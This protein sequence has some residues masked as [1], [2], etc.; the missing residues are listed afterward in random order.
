MPTSVN[1]ARKIQ[2]IINDFLTPEQA[3]EVTRRLDEEV[4]KNTDN[5]SLKVSLSMLRGLYER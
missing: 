1:E 4:G 3:R 5:D 2:E